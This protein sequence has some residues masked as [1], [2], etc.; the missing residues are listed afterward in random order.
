[1]AAYLVFTREKMRDKAEYDI[2]APKARAS[3]AALVELPARF[4]CPGH[5]RPLTEGAE[6]Q[7]GSLRER[8]QETAWPLLG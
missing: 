3:M 6:D 1:M 7:L 4:V 8:V 5:R 2:Y